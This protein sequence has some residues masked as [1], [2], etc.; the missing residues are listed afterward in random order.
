[1]RKENAV[2]REELAEKNKTIT[3]L[4][5]QLNKVDQAARSSSLRIIGLPVNSTTPQAE[6]YKIVFQEILQPVF[7][8]AKEAGEL[9]SATFAPHF[10]VNNVFAVP[11]KK[12]L[13][14]P[15]I[16]TLSSQYNRGLIFKYKKTALPS[17]HDSVSNRDRPKYLI[18]E[19][20][21][22][23]NFTQLRAIAKEDKV[24]SAWS[25]GGQLRFRLHNS[26]TVYKVKSLMDTVDS[27]TKSTG[28]PIILSQ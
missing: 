1:M 25:F 14:C 13:S 12:G 6:V 21:S 22:P 20:L 17:V 10:L 3:H 5:E 15:V 28:T 9:P 16:L 2:L 11:G 4:T 24:K 26:L 19:D 23:A 7:L 8:A 27:I 18:F